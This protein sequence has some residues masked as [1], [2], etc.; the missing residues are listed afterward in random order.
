MGKDR[1]GGKHVCRGC[2]VRNEEQFFPS[3]G[4][5]GR[6]PHEQLSGPQGQERPAQT[7]PSLVLLGGPVPC[8]RRAPAGW[9]KQLAGLLIPLKG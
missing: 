6:S 8:L 4:P 1:L 5:P 9:G 3:L 7:D 2:E